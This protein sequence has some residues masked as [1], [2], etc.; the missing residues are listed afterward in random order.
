MGADDVRI[1]IELMA[2]MGACLL[3]LVAWV[4]AGDRK[5]MDLLGERVT[6]LERTALTRKEAV[7]LLAERGEALLRNLLSTP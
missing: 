6:E 5:R 4:Y 3:G 7:E 1:Y 2:L